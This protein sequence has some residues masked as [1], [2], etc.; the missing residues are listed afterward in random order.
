MN[1]RKVTL[2][3]VR[4]IDAAGDGAEGSG[5]DRRFIGRIV[6]RQNIEVRF[7]PPAEFE[8]LSLGKPPAKAED[9]DTGID[10]PIHLCLLANRSPLCFDGDP[11][12]L[13]NP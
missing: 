12:P 13:F 7:L 1:H 6:I 9:N 8:V 4:F 11:I 3:G 5:T 10:L 2:K